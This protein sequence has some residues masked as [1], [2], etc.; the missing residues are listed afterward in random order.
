MKRFVAVILVIAFAAGAAILQADKKAELYLAA[1][2]EKD[3][4]LKMQK[5][6][7]YM[8]TYGKKKKYQSPTLFLHLVETAGALKQY[9]KVEKYAAMALKNQQMSAMD[10][11]MV[12]LQLAYTQ[13]YAKKDLA[14]ATKIADEILEFTGTADSAQVERLLTA[15]ALRIQIAALEARA[16]GEED[17]IKAL[18]NSIRVYRIDHSARSAGFV[19]H[20][21]KKLYSEYNNIKKAIEGLK[22]IADI[23]NADLEHQDQLAAW[24]VREGIENEARKYLKLSYAREKTARKAHTIG[25]LTYIV[26][27]DEGL[28]YLAEAV[29]LEEAPYSTDAREL[30]LENV[31]VEE[32]QVAE[33]ETVDQE[34]LRQAHE[35]AVEKL[36]EEAR[37]RLNQ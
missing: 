15:P 23:P 7:E 10:K 30:M 36:V 13:I 20:F 31:T 25:K 26:D 1:I 19:F 6:E 18:E 17:I 4:E 14:A 16:E 11:A 12:N 8:D 35:Q 5:L 37:S 28:R 29:A 27:L 2:T 34:A 9:D 32:P 33:G 24:L 3:P 21:S 22:V